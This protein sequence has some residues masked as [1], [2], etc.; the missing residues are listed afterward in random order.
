MIE[1]GTREDPFIKL[2][3]SAYEAGAW[4]KSELTKPDAIDRTNPAVDQIA[5]LITNGKKLAVEHT[6]IE[7]FVGDKEDFAFF[8]AAFLKIEQ[9]RTL[10]VPDKFIQVFVPVGTLKNKPKAARDLIVRAVHS[11]IR[12]NGPRLFAGEF[13]HPCSITEISSNSPFEITLTVKTQTAQSPGFVVRRQQVANTLDQVVEK[14][15]RKK[16]PKLANTPADKRILLLERQHMILVPSS[17]LSEIERWR[18]SFPALTCVDEIWFLETIFY[19]TAL[20]GTYLRFERF[21][22]GKVVQSFDF[23]SGKLTSRFEYGVSEVMDEGGTGAVTGIQWQPP[24][25]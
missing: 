17:I 3:L 19:G 16:L 7:P 10:V 2:F 9:D 14:A 21:D 6:I 15:L 22:N 12:S 4:A 8:E 23:E 18:P 13:Q 1:S 24:K 11:W 20:G 25:I 5:T